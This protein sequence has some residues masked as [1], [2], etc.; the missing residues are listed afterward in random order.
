[1]LVPCVWHVPLSSDFRLALLFSLRTMLSM[2]LFVDCSIVW[3]VLAVSTQYWL[4]QLEQTFESQ[5][6]SSIL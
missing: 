6:T 1:M 2:D 4:R 3:S 5:L